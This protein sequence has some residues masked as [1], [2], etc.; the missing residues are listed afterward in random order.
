MGQDLYK[1]EMALSELSDLDLAHVKSVSKVKELKEI[2][3][4]MVKQ[5]RDLLQKCLTM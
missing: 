1:L 2:F 5:K 4:K 3:T